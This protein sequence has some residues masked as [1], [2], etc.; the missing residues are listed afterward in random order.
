[1][2]GIRSLIRSVAIAACVAMAAWS[3]G[4]VAQSYPSKPVRILVG[5]AAGGPADVVARI[6]SRRLATEL[7]QP[8]IVENK[9]GAD[10]RIAAQLVASATP[11]GH[12]IA[13]VDSGLAVNAVLFAQK[14]YDPVKDF[15]PLFFIGDIP[16]FIVSTPSLQV[17]SLREFIDYAKANP[18][19]L[20]YAA[21]ASS[22]MLAGEMLKHVAGIDVVRVPYKGAAM[23]IPALLS[24][25]V[26]CMVSAVGGL[27]PLVKQGK[28]KA[29]AVTASK[30]THLAPDV[31]TT[32]EAGLPGMVYVNW[33]AIVGPAGVS[34]PIA[35]HLDA[36]LRKVVADPEV[37]QQL[38]NMGLEPSPMTQEA[39]GAM[40]KTE[41][42][43]LDNLVKTA[44]IGVRE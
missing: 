18:G 34:Q 27:A 30:R 2:P 3:T 24:G 35:A 9:P 6:L 4:T 17:D 12:T 44:N 23:G 14:P 29:L 39:F 5:F 8:V 32:A 36:A 1:M 40:I 33:Y 7:G 28:I 15:T 11:D 42:G 25:E 19:K 21:T 37:R 26:H 22:T 13:L 43:K 16:N 41:V 38:L 31:P 20:N 10:S